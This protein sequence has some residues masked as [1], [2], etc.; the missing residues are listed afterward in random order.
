MCL[1]AVAPSLRIS[2]HVTPVVP[3]TERFDGRALLRPTNW[4]RES[5][6]YHE[7]AIFSLCT[8]IRLGHRPGETIPWSLKSHHET[9]GGG[10]HS[11]WS[12]TILNI[13]TSFKLS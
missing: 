11:R 1:I 3:A 9:L 8:S 12:R 6:H 4:D 2:A 7:I 5:D 10:C 13:I